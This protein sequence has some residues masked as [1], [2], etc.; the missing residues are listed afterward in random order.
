M[1]LTFFFFQILKICIFSFIKNHICWKQ[2]L[3]ILPPKNGHFFF[4]E[5]GGRNLGRGLHKVVCF[6]SI[7][8]SELQKFS[9]RHRKNISTWKSKFD[10]SGIGTMFYWRLGY[11]KSLFSYL[12]GSTGILLKSKYYPKLAIWC[13]KMSDFLEISLLPIFNKIKFSHELNFGTETAS[14]CVFNFLAKIALKAKIITKM[15]I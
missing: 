12:L 9:Y 11:A 10:T 3:I 2:H 6:A 14:T 13:K 7:F 1:L 8:F 15:G 4:L 5:G